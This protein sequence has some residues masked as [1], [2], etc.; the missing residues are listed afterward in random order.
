MIVK[1]LRRLGI[2]FRA[3]KRALLDAIQFAHG[4]LADA[5]F[6]EHWDPDAARKILDML[7]TDMTKHGCAFTSYVCDDDAPVL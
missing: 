5:C 2:V 3:D 4:A 6:S 7:E 1:L